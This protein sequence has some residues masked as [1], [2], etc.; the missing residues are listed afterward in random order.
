[1]NTQKLIAG[2]YDSSILN[3]LV[4]LHAVFHNENTNL[5]SYQHCLRGPFP[6]HPHQHRLFL[7]YLVITILTGMLLLLLLLS[8]FSR[9]QL[10]VTP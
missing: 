1:M 8:H 5:R 6:P 7:A 3:F 9:L 10:C 2:S 4:N